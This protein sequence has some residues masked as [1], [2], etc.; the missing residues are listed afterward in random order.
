MKE[1][2]R[3][4]N[5]RFTELENQL[6]KINLPGKKDNKINSEENSQ[7]VTELWG[8]FSNQIDKL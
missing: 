5:R 7:E 4:D 6:K 1:D 3:I 2:K 8:Y